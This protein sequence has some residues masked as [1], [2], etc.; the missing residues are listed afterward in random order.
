MLDIVK[1]WI[2]SH[3]MDPDLLQVMEDGKQAQVKYNSSRDGKTYSALLDIDLDKEWVELSFTCRAAFRKSV[4]GQSP[5]CL[6]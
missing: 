3:E 1:A 5:N 6:R 2:K 4:A